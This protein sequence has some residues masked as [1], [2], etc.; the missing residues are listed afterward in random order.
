V[1]KQQW[2]FASALSGVAILAFIGLS[3]WQQG[4]ELDKSRQEA[5]AA[6]A[7]AGDQA[8]VLSNELARVQGEVAALQQE[9]EAAA[10]AQKNIED[11]MRSALQSK[12][13]TISQLQG[14][15]T[16]NI[17]DR[18]LFN[19]G[20]ADVKPEGEK[21]LRQIA[22]VLSQYPRR[23]IH[24]VGHTDNVPIRLIARNRFP[25]NWELSTARATA[26]VRLLCEQAGVDPKR[27]AAVGYG[28]YHPAADNSTEEGRA[29]NRR[30]EIVVLPEEFSNLAPAPPRSPAARAS[31]G[32]NAAS[33]G[34]QPPPVGGT[35]NITGLTNAPG[36]TNIAGMTNPPAGEKG[37]NQP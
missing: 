14:R 29:K 9:K 20:E 17:L 15:L 4:R 6:R 34:G 27:L 37:T 28:E 32:T 19:S 11:S 3:F 2:I 5:E 31:L 18:I 24:V 22:S 1:T 12:E 21:I 26:A 36:I 16:V 10:T 7:R 13:V 30:I 23:Q 25:S 8:G 35:T 33:L